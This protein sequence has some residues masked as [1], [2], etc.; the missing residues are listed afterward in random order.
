MNDTT[1]KQ[2][3]TGA[4]ALMRS[5]QNEGVPTQYCPTLFRQTNGS[6]ALSYIF[7]ARGN[8]YGV[9]TEVNPYHIISSEKANIRCRDIF[10]AGD[11]KTIEKDWK[12]YFVLDFTEEKS[13]NIYNSDDDTIYGAASLT[14]NVKKKIKQ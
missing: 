6:I 7:Y 10:G 2:I 3:I 14:L 4:E 13:S 11:D 5:L 1:Q 12:R 8:G 9:S